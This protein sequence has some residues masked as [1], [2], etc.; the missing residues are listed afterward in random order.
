MSNLFCINKSGQNIPIY[1]ATNQATQIGTI[2]NREAFGYDKNWGGDGYFC[3][4]LFKNSSGSLSYGFII[5]PPNNAIA[6][7]TDYPYG[8][9]PI[10]G[11]QYITFL[12]R[13][14]RNVYTVGGTNWGTVA[15]NRRVAC[16]NATAGDRHPDW[17]SIYYV[18]NT[19]GQWIPVTGDGANYGFVDSGLSV[20]SGYGSIPMY[21]SW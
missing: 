8:T 18:E 20:A 2:Y 13:S 5:D 3:H 6:K 16:I 14:S 11:Q 10:H 19:R 9:A 15:A 21:G 7:C 17:K 4:I 12:M 1:S